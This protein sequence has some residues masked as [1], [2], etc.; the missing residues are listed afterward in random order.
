M[1]DSDKVKITPLTENSDYSLW[2]IRVRAAISAKGLKM[3]L[4]AANYTTSPKTALTDENKEQACNIIVAALGDQ[5][6]RVV[7]DVIDNPLGMLEKLDSRYDSKSTATRIAKFSELVSIKY[8]S[9]KDDMS[10]HVDRL[11]GL[12]AQLRRMGTNFDE[13]LAIGILVASVEAQ[14]LLSVT[15]AIKTI[16][17]KDL[18]WEDVASRL[19]DEVRSARRSSDRASA[20]NLTC[21]IC[22]KP[23]STD[24]CFLNPL[25]PNHRLN[26]VKDPQNGG[27]DGKGKGGGGRAAMAHVGSG[28]GGRQPD[29]M[30][31]DSGTTAHMT[32]RAERVSMKTACESSVQLAD[33]SSMHSESMGTRTVQWITDSGRESVHLSNTL[34]CPDV[35]ISLLSVPALV[36]KN[37]AVMFLPG[38]GF[39]VDL[40]D[41]CSILGT[42]EQDE[43]GLFYISDNQK[44]VPAGKNA[45]TESGFTAMIAIA[46]KYT[47]LATG[48]PE[49]EKTKPT[50]VKSTTEA[51]IWHRRLGHALPKAD[52]S[53]HINNKSLPHGS[54]TS[55]DCEPCAKGKFRR[56]FPG[57][58]TKARRIGRLH[59]DTKGKVNVESADGHRYFL[60]VV[61]EYS[62]FTKAFP[63]RSKSEAS[64]TL[65][66]YI[67]RFEKQSGYTIAAVHADGGSEF[68]RAFEALDRD[69]VETST[70]TTYT[71]ESN[72]LAERTHGIILSMARTVLSQAAFPEKFWHY[73]VRHVTECRNHVRHSVTKS[74][75]HI[76]VFGT[77]SRELT[78]IRPFGCRVLYRPAVKQLSTFEPRVRDGV[79][80]HHEGGGLYRILTADG[81]VR[82][83]HVRFE[84]HK[85]PGIYSLRTDDAESDSDDD[86]TKSVSINL[87][88]D[89]NSD[90]EEEPD[91]PGENADENQVNDDDS[92]DAHDDSERESKDDDNDAPR[93]EDMTYTPA[94]PSRYG[95]TDDEDGN[96]TADDEPG[97]SIGPRLRSIPRV[98]YSARA[99]PDFI[100]TSDEPSMGEAMVSPERKKWL[101]AI[102]EE[103]S[104]LLS[105]G[106]WK[107]PSNIPPGTRVLPS[108]I[109]LRL[110][111]DSAGLPARFKG[112]VVVRGNLQAESDDYLEHYA[113]VACIELVRTVFAV[114]AALGWTIQLVDVKGAFL[115][116]SL[117][118]EERIFI[119]LPNVKGVETASGQVVELVK[120]LYGLRQ[121]PKLWYA[122]FA[123]Q[124]FRI[125]FRRSLVSDCLFI[126]EGPNP[127]YIIAYVDDL[128]VFGPDSAVADVKSELVKLFTVT[129]LGEC[130][131]FLGIKV[132]RKQNGVFLS[133]KAYTERIIE[134]A[135]MANSK[136]VKAPLTLGHPLYDQRV[137]LNEKEADE[138]SGVPYRAVLGALLYLSTRTRPD[139]ATAVSLL[140]KFQAEPNPKHWKALKHVMRY[141]QG[142]TDFGIWL[143]SGSAIPTLEV[144]CDADW[145]RDQDRRRSRTGY[146]LTI[147][148]GPVIWSSKLQSSTAESSTEAEFTALA[149]CVGEVNWVRAVLSELGFPPTGPTT[150]HQDNL[151]AIAW[152]KDV[153]GLRNVKHIGIKYYVVR[154]AV[155]NDEVEVRFISTSDNRA[156]SLTKTLAGD[157]FIQHRDWLG[158]RTGNN[159]A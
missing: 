126:R 53:S 125:G 46:K 83:K 159:L 8:T 45:S 123:K 120:S 95:E 44:S 138:M 57:S 99:I 42:F 27:K 152:T 43:D 88:D 122:F 158:V 116:A 11:A 24:R 70:T 133:Q 67:K 103:F 68:T 149:K 97:H 12:I 140:G 6:L 157:S 15:A 34:I 69:G 75:P 33:N 155:E 131:H 146:L 21:S 48:K 25:N 36:N 89:E 92:N 78:H 111:R 58:L 91:Q 31:I 16:S 84:E 74:V 134:K 104:T 119:K 3:T 82:T 32:A 47:V 18:K 62:R 41:D 13:T 114:A 72:G 109:I 107:S 1:T 40:E 86:G 5:A 4:V 153:Q 61:E 22:K 66:R 7:V 118:K 26:L 9:V 65:L 52:V 28:R 112:R 49:P 79:N 129:D 73:A 124:I 110:K 35:A 39:L 113:P 10:K 85:F 106:T 148:G 64:D 87:S 50:K 143:P 100:T 150:V 60:T 30:M 141:L 156:D 145:G 29:R 130:N 81:I 23:H 98:H 132:E 56:S 14:P 77:R 96:D 20:A 135:G 17:E 136:P 54:C 55:V 142:T 63:L 105:N 71:P 115:H 117:P 102:K 137:P 151:G 19:M 128:L 80:L 59:V 51:T 90:S 144:W 121:A 154:D 101:A 139:I 2:R 127:V 37:I 76:T 108:G 93:P 38:A 147:G 94:E